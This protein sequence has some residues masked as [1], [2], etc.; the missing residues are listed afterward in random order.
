MGNGSLV[1]QLD[2]NTKQ[3]FGLT[4]ELNFQKVLSCGDSR[5]KLIR[6]RK[7]W[8][9]ANNYSKGKGGNLASMK[10]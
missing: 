7:S 6:M 8:K 10:S 4:S 3:V 9:D 2:M 5:Y 1:I